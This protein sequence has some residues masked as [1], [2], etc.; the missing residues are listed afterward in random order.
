[1]RFLW[2]FFL[3]LTLGPGVEGLIEGGSFSVA[4]YITYETL[5][6]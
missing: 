3:V 1:M 6:M 4:V 2:D 5:E